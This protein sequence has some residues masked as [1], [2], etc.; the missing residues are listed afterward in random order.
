MRAFKVRL[1][2]LSRGA[3]LAPSAPTAM[4][5][6]VSGFAVDAEDIDEAR[7]ACAFRLC[8]WGYE[9]RSVSCLARGDA[10]LAAVV[11]E[12]ALMPVAAAG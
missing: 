11:Y 7:R 8:E 6:E 3:P 2:E 1:F 12:R 5:R 4:P 9:V 10:A